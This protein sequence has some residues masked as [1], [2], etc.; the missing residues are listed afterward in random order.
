[1]LSRSFYSK[2][3]TR[4][5]QLLLGPL[6]LLPFHISHGPSLYKIMGDLYRMSVI[7][8][9]ESLFELTYWMEEVLLSGF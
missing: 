7:W 9:R 3:N 6:F 1:M 5:A 8:A 2:S 4:Q